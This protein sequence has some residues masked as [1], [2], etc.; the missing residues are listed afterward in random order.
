MDTDQIGYTVNRQKNFFL[1]I[2]RVKKKK[3][4]IQ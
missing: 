2:K 3:V 1:V 4:S